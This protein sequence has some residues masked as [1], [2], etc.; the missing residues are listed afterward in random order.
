M[1]RVTFQPAGVTV[2]VAA[3]TS[4]LDAARQA[5]VP[6]RNDCA[7]QGV[8]GRCAV[9][10][11]RGSV[12]RLPTRHRLRAG[13]DLACRVL[14]T[15]S[16]L[17]VSLPRESREWDHSVSLRSVAPPSGAYPPAG[18]VIE[19]V[20]VD[21]SPP[22]L[23][24]NVADAERLSVHLNRRRGGTH[25]MPLSVLHNLP[26]RLRAGEW[27]PQVILS[28]EP[29]ET[30]ILD[31]GPVV[32]SPVVVLA[33]DIGTTS[34]KARLLGS[35][36]DL[37]ASCYNSQ[38]VF[39][40]DVISRIIHCQREHPDGSRQLQQ[41]VVDDINRLLAALLERS[42]L[43]GD[44]VWGAVFS[45][46]TTM[47]HLFL[48]LYPEWIRREPYVGCSYHPPVVDAARVGVGINP[49]GRVFCLPAVSSFVGGDITAGIL[50]T[51]LHEAERPAA[52]IDLGTNGEIA[53][54]CKDFMVCCSAS[55]GPAFE[56][57]GSASGTR[58]R[59][60]AVDRAWSD[61]TVRW[62]TMG[63]GPPVG[64]CGT[65][66]ID[67]LA[68]LLQEGA[69]D[70]TGRFLDGAPGVRTAEDE[71]H[72]YVVAPADKTAV[73]RDVVLTQAD[74]DNLVRAKG[75]IY[76]AGSIL[77]D[78]L[79]ME[80]KDLS[81]IMLAGGFGERLDKE[82]AVT[83]GLLP[84]VPRERIEFVGN[85]SL[86][87]AVTVA[88]DAGSYERAREIA[89]GTTYFELSTHLGF[90]DQFVSACFLPHTDAEK[91]PSVAAAG[92]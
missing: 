26:R 18:G 31:V 14:L 82:S 19:K 83:I 29:T 65:G 49:A 36:D 47:E 54:G 73:G 68:V 78:S 3:G 57:G 9:E 64:I 13:L 48:G 45:G 30:R 33:V 89:A 79:G 62:E 71:S 88:A 43:S 37:V 75:A 44:D 53:I 81:S 58:A 23:E 17:E 90:M 34:V 51:R 25:R 12:S 46:N 91:F 60:G 35:G 11:T 40:P 55:A 84:D 7:G 77:L 59:D 52:L 24:D 28:T 56:G 86:R 32:D 2:D 20:V 72:E 22:N 92:R 4:L 50:A 74:V 6:L 15:D 63:G 8:C 76:A 27:R 80:W 39:G 21:L 42:G 61:G 10:I 69:L 87:G 70:R 66:Y 1:P 67:L 85:T 5:Q 41:L 38:A 16:D